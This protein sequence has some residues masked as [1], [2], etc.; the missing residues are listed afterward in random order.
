MTRSHVIGAMAPPLREQTIGEA[1]HDSARRW[2]E[3]EALVSVAEGVR[4]S[5]AKLAARAADIVAGLLGLGLRPGDRIGIWSPND[6]GWALTQFATAKAGLILVAI[7]PA[8]PALRARARSED[9]SGDCGTVCGAPQD[10]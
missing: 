1:L 5:F 2:P 4:L 3:R 7:N 10:Q 9:A 6:V 8:C